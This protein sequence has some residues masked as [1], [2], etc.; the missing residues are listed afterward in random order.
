MTEA[1]VICWVLIA[2]GIVTIIVQYREDKLH[3]RD[4]TAHP[5]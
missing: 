3:Q 2:L 1:L 5:A 4:N